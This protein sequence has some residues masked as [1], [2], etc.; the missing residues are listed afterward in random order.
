MVEGNLYCLHNPAFDRQ[1]RHYYKLGRTQDLRKRLQTYQTGYLEPCVYVAVGSRR[2]ASSEAAELVLFY[3]LRRFRVRENREFFNVPLS[4]V[5]HML[6]RVSSLSDDRLDDIAKLIKAT[7]DVNKFMSN[8]AIDSL[9]AS[10][11]TV[12]IECRTE[13]TEYADYLDEFFEKFRF[14]PREE[15]V[16]MYKKFG[17]RTVEDLELNTLL[18]NTKKV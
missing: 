7:R 12:E 4:L 10:F 17:Y 1:G 15:D 5:R 3:L 13:K 6:I 16:E 14:K 2:F 18:D 8:N 11:E 9:I